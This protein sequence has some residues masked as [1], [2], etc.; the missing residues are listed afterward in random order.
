MCVGLLLLAPFAHDF[1]LFEG[2]V[3]SPGVTKAVGAV[4][5]LADLAALG[6]ATRRSWSTG[7]T[8]CLVGVLA[9]SLLLNVCAEVLLFGLPVI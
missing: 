7:R 1:L 5:L 8:R 3:R 6:W 9:G 2:S 4:V